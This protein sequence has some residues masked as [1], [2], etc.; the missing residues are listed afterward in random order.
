VDKPDAVQTN[1][2]IGNPGIYRTHPDRIPVW[3]VNT[4]FGGRFTSVLNEELR[5]NSA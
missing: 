2:S 1:F 4:L 3:L 5:V